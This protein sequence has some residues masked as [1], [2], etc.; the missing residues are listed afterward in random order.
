MIYE[1]MS[2]S[3][4]L[5]VDKVVARPPKGIRSERPSSPL[6]GSLFL[7]QSDSGSFMMLYTGIPNIDDGWEM[8]GAQEPIPTNFKYRQVINYSYLAGGYKSSSPWKNVH[9]TVN[10]TDQ[11]NHVGELLD[12]PASY[13]SGA[14]SKSIFFMWSVNDDGA[15]K[16]ASNIH[17]TTTSAV[18]MIT[19]TNY[20]HTTAMNTTISRSD[21]G[22]M[23]KETE[24]AYLF[25]GGSATVELFNLSTESLHTA[26]T[27]TTINGSDGGSAFS[28]ENHGYGWTSSAG[29]KLNF[30]TETF[31]TSDR[32]GNHSQQK[33][34]SSKVGKG[35]AGNEGSYSGGY[36]LRRWDNTSDTNIGNVVKPHPNC[37]EENFTMGQDHQYMLGN[38]D[39]LQNNTSW[40]FIY[41]TDTGTTSVQGLNPGVNAGTSS[42]H[43]GWRE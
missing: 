1:N 35:Y 31:A 32:W 12:Y 8:I 11:T 2:V 34:I 25:S 20:A 22:C 6:S 17:G 30:A 27:L 14:C 3:G 7:E 29:V 43:C 15:W 18:N 13:T 33:G 5:N 9:K 24:M 19:D 41:S 21:L 10:A 39:G 42:G 28:D 16:S 40:K 26:Y 23:F 38:Y 36:N 4:S 37:G